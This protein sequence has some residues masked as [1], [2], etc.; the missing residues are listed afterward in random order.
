MLGF[1]NS[2][3][4]ENDLSYEIHKDRKKRLRI[5]YTLL[6]LLG[7]GVIYLFLYLLSNQSF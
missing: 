1:V 7:G 6:A 3:K 2:E 5:T 4:K